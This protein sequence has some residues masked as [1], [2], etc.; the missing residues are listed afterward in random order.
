MMSSSNWKKKKVPETEEG[1]EEVGEV[2]AESGMK[3][4]RKWRKK[5]G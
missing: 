3:R 2:R 4:G 5:R 1:D